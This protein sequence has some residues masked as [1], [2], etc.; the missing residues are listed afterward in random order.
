MM[1]RSATEIDHYLDDPG[2]LAVSLESFDPDQYLP[3]HSMVSTR[4]HYRSEDS[5]AESERSS[6]PWSPPAWRKGT[7]AWQQHNTPRKSKSRSRSRRTGTEDEDIDITLIPANVPLPVSPEKG[8]P[9]YSV[10][11]TPDQHREQSVASLQRRRRDSTLDRDASAQPELPNNFIRFAVRAE[12]QHRTEPFE[13]ALQWLREKVDSVIFNSKSLMYAFITVILAYWTLKMLLGAPSPPPVP[14]LLKVAEVAKTFEPLIYHTDSGRKQINQL[15]TTGYA[16]YDLGASVQYASNLNKSKEIADD[17]YT[18]SEIMKKLVI[19]LTDFFSKVE[20]DVD[21]IIYMMDWAKRYLDRLEPTQ[22]GSMTT[23]TDNLQEML[24]QAGISEYRDGTP[25]PV[26][27]MMQF[28]FRGTTAQRNR[29]KLKYTFDEV[30]NA[31]ESS[32][33][34]Q[35]QIA[36]LLYQ[37]FEDIDKIYQNLAT[38]ALHEVD[39]QDAEENELLSSAWVRIMGPRKNALTKFEKN[40]DLLGTVRL[41]TTQHKD[42]L[43]DFGQKLLLMKS[44]LDYIREDLTVAMVRTNGTSD[45]P[46]EEQMASLDDTYKVLKEVRDR[47]KAQL[48]KF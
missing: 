19:D 42:V 15:Q 37:K 47:Q 38:T 16:V 34:T 28:M 41:Q 32:I 31:V 45:L 17:L 22:P 12:V 39:Q 5:E 9:L 4:S 18:V 21:G 27:H 36:M 1:S 44:N 6:T 23:I 11:P 40:R 25:N 10:E 8:T 29:Q 7:S 14:N 26:G 30:L 46:I 24:S 2:S 20:G 48:R 3:A 43:K 35:L 13:S 33:S